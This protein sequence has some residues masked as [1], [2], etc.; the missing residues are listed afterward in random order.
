MVFA[1]RR[2][3]EGNLGRFALDAVEGFQLAKKPRYAAFTDRLSGIGGASASLPVTARRTALMAFLT[4]VLT[5][6]LRSRAL[7]LCL[8]LLIADL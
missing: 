3:L 4:R 2:R 6:R 7:R 8:C 5:M 1:R